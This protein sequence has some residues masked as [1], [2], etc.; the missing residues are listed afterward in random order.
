MKKFILLIG[1]IYLNATVSCGAVWNCRM[2]QFSCR[3]SQALYIHLARVHNRWVC[4]Y[5]KKYYVD[6]DNF[7]EH[8]QSAHA[9]RTCRSC[10][11]LTFKNEEEYQAH[12]SACHK[13]STHY[14]WA[15]GV[16]KKKLP[17][18]EKFVAHVF[19][20]HE[21][22]ACLDCMDK[23]KLTIN[24]F[25]DY[26]LY[27]IHMRKEHEK[28]TCSK[29]VQTFK[30]EKELNSHYSFCHAEKNS[31]K[32]SLCEPCRHV[33]R[34][35]C[36]AEKTTHEFQHVFLLVFLQ[37]TICNSS[38]CCESYRKKVVDKYA[39]VKRAKDE[40]WYAQIEIGNAQRKG[41]EEKEKKA[42]NAE[43]VARDKETKSKANTIEA[44]RE[45]ANH[46][47]E[48]HKLCLFCENELKDASKL[49]KSLDSSTWEQIGDEARTFLQV[50]ETTFSEGEIPVI[51][52]EMC[53]SPLHPNQKTQLF[54]VSSEKFPY[55]ESYPFNH[56]E[57][58]ER[59]V[60]KNTIM[61]AIKEASEDEEIFSKKN[62]ENNI[63]LNEEDEEKDE[64]EDEEYGEEE[65]EEKEEKG[66]NEDKK[67]EEKVTKP[68]IEK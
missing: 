59:K 33:I 37:Q 51:P 39:E 63:I 50:K 65:D 66:K 13:P 24:T 10:V 57:Y 23:E 64:L 5:C 67:E 8:M 6:Y 42:K 49:S 16:C 61:S 1:M 45:F 52:C 46:V 48:V 68:K 18:L 29:C 60:E 38:P 12:L 3:E 35:R 20:Q 62:G 9:R 47:L 2:C 43:T 25:N 28:L 55:A 41:N 19:D 34:F 40:I 15:C 21:R 53:G 54:F 56:L 44:V 7:K 30:K 4:S 26:E 32:M 31:V 14:K 11:T 36:R 22:Y 58:S 27:Q 17:T